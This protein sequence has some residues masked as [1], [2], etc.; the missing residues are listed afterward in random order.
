MALCGA[1]V[2][3]RAV[4]RGTAVARRAGDRPGDR[5]AGRDPHPLS[6]PAL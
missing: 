3:A 6:R 4:G 2:M 1:A 5:H